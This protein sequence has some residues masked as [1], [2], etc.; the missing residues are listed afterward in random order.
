MSGN[1]IIALMKTKLQYVKTLAAQHPWVTRSTIAMVV[2]IILWSGYGWYQQKRIAVEMSLVRPVPVMA[3]AVEQRSMPVIVQSFGDLRAFAAADLSAESSGEIVEISFD[4]GQK[5]E[6]GTVLAT[7]DN[8]TQKANLQKAKAD[9]ELKQIEYNRNLNLVKRGAQ[10]QQVLDVAK[11]ELAASSAEVLA[12]Q[13][14]LEKTTLKAPFTGR[15]GARVISIGQY[16]SPGQALIEIVDAEQLKIQFSVP[17]RYLNQLAVGQQVDITTEAYRDRTFAGVVDYVAPS[18]DS[19]TRTIGVEA[20]INNKDNVLSPGLSVQVSQVL[21]QDDA[22]LVVPEESL[23]YSLEGASVFIAEDDPEF[24]LDERVRKV[25]LQQQSAQRNIPVD[26]LP[27]LQIKKVKR[28]NV[29]TATFIDGIVQITD[30][31]KVGQL[32][33]TQGQQKLRDGAIV[34][35]V[36]PAK[37]MQEAAA[38]EA[39]VK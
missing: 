12:M 39:S 14:A 19:V 20:L 1:E 29:Q 27:P 18:I 8:E 6:A 32:V 34:M 33:V 23:V 15:L 21:A 4:G 38:A 31:L 26:E 22:A 37:R 10:P 35:L 36:D 25:I 7:I 3:V 9:Y 13:D 2:L 24:E 5:V 28:V 16:V 30:G 17:E 11:A